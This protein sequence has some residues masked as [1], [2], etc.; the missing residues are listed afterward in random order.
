MQYLLRKNFWISPTPPHWGIVVLFFDHLMI[1]RV[2]FLCMCFFRSLA[3]PTLTHRF[4]QRYGN[5]RLSDYSYRAW[6]IIDSPHSLDCNRQN[7]SAAF[8][9]CISNCN[10][11]IFTLHGMLCT[12][13]RG[14]YSPWMKL[15]PLLYTSEVFRLLLMLNI[16]N[17]EFHYSQIKKFLWR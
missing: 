2:W 9:L 3:L 5:Q 7:Q 1:K 17:Q 11:L 6:R 14:Q 10:Q 8:V 15:L 16:W 13:K 12:V 4:W